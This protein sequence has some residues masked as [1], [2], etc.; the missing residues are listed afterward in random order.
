MRHTHTHTA[1]GA[2]HKR[3]RKSNINL[4]DLCPCTMSNEY[5][6]RPY[7]YIFGSVKI[8]FNHIFGNRIAT[9]DYIPPL[10]IPLCC[11]QTL[12]NGKNVIGWIHL[13]ILHSFSLALWL[14][15]VC[16][17]ACVFESTKSIVCRTSNMYLDNGIQ[18]AIS[19]GASHVRHWW[20]LINAFFKPS[21]KTIHTIRQIPPFGNTQV[22]QIKVR[23]N[24]MSTVNPASQTRGDGGRRQCGIKGWDAF[25]CISKTATNIYI[26]KC[27]EKE[28]TKER[29][30]KTGKYNN[31]EM[32]MHSRIVRISLRKR[33]VRM[34]QASIFA[35]FFFIVQ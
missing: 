35:I 18:L 1:N 16:V 22:M 8:T 7:I 33:I 4:C 13:N 24:Y 9:P 27:P 30:K 32:V 11:A 31:V 23:Y 2:V 28:W 26:R 12:S 3:R 20:F 14:V 34:V 10:R 15:C 25:M 5:A 6:R 29:E 19:F 17:C 21:A